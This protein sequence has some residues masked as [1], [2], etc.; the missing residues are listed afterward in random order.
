MN[1]TLCLAKAAYEYCRT[2][3]C[4]ENESDSLF[5]YSDDESFESISGCSVEYDSDLQAKVQ[6]ELA[7]D[8]SLLKDICCYD[9][10]DDSETNDSGSG[11]DFACLIDGVC[12]GQEDGKIVTKSLNSR[13][14][15]SR[16]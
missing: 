13:M 2:N 6:A 12:G 10:D 9:D 11:C 14:H 15:S 1:K 16:L 7:A 5:T 4:I 8:T 3:W